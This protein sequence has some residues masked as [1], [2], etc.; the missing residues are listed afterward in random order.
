[1][2]FNNAI[3]LVTDGPPSVGAA[4]AERLKSEDCTVVICGRDD[5]KPNA[6]AARPGATTV[7]GDAS[8][9]ADGP[10]PLGTVE[11]EFGGFDI[12]VNCAVVLLQ[13]DQAQVKDAA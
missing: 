13:H 10:N 5:A 12:L 7:R 9:L 3:V 4:L 11:R 1:M 6:A 2:T 8:N